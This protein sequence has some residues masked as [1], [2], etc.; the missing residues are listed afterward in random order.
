MNLPQEAMTYHWATEC[1]SSL[2][3]IVTYQEQSSGWKE[4]L[5]PKAEVGLIWKCTLLWH[6]CTDNDRPNQ[7][8]GMDSGS[9]VTQPSRR[10]PKQNWN[11]TTDAA[12]KH[13]S[14]RWVFWN[15]RSFYFYFCLQLQLPHLKLCAWLFETQFWNYYSEM[16]LLTTYTA[17]HDGMK[18]NTVVV[19]VSLF[20]NSDYCCSER[21]QAHIWPSIIEY[22]SKGILYR[23]NCP[24][25]MFCCW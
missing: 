24:V 22:T 18:G 13:P 14:S 25:T 20:Q 8:I 5:H 3:M 12:V 7:I 19:M 1:L 10:K 4:A 11:P 2:Q 17:T 6:L 21:F 23:A 15:H 9:R 16:L